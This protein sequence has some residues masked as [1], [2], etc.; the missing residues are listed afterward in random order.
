MFLNQCTVAGVVSDTPTVR[1]LDS[2]QQVTSLSI[3]IDDEGK[4]GRVF[5]TYV[6][7]EG[8]GTVADAL[9]DLDEGQSVCITGK[10]AYRTWTGKDGN[11]QGG[12]RVM[13]WQVQPVKPAS[14]SNNS[15]SAAYSLFQ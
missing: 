9:Q 1:Y 14:Y 4:G 10:L 3:R 11:K 12:L 13:A 5:K 2:G 15:D 7:V 6:Q 8:Y